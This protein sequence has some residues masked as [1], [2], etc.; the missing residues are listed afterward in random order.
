[1]KSGKNLILFI[2]AW[3]GIFTMLLFFKD[4]YLKH[5]EKVKSEKL[6]TKAIYI[7]KAIEYIA[8]EAKHFAKNIVDDIETDLII[9]YDS[10]FDELE[11]D[12]DKTKKGSLEA[13]KNKEVVLNHI[14]DVTFNKVP[15]GSDLANSNDPIQ[16]WGDILSGD[17]ST[18]CPD[19]KNVVRTKQIETSKHLH[20]E[21]G[22]QAYDDMTKTR[23]V[24]TFWHF[25]QS[26]HKEK[27]LNYTGGTNL[28]NLIAWYLE[29]N[30]DD[31][32]LRSFEFFGI[33]RDNDYIDLFENRVYSANGTYNNSSNRITIA[34]GFDLFTQLEFYPHLKFQ[35]T[36][37]NNEISYITEK[38]I[39]TNYLFLTISIVYAVIVTMLFIYFKD[40][41]VQD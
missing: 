9:E 32:L 35:L 33:A 38:I 15:A 10:D 22:K 4:G 12:V 13:L 5:L 31:N 3:I 37:I 25:K 14:T 17:L 18:D 6:Q 30:C 8:F 36:E 41:N 20:I 24:F 40:H 7:Q 26:K 1:M 19:P 23:K 11:K 16:F 21:L 28:D 2:I 29:N 34:Q 39:F 27:I